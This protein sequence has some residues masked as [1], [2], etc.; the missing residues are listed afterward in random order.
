[1]TTP[2]PYQRRPAPRTAD[3][4]PTTIR[5]DPQESTDVDRWLLELRLEA[6]LRQLDKAEVIRELVRMAMFPDGVIRHALLHR[7]RA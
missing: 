3:A 5:F 7:L 2:Q 4:V 1:M 6:G